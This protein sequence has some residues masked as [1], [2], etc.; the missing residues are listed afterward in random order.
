MMRAM[1]VLA[2]VACT[3]AEDEVPCVTVERA[4]FPHRVTA[5]GVLRA[6][7]ATSIVAP[8]YDLGSLTLT[9]LAADG[10]IIEKDGVIARFDRTRAE[11]NLRD[12]QIQVAI[13]EASVRMQRLDA[14]AVA[15]TREVA[16]MTA[17]RDATEARTV[18]AIDPLLYSRNQIIESSLDENLARARLAQAKRARATGGNISRANLELAILAHKRAVSS[19]EQAQRVLANVEVRAPH[20]GLFLVQRDER[21]DIP[22]LGS[23]VWQEQAL[24]ELPAI[25]HMEAQLFVLE[26]DG[27]G[28]AAGQPANIVVASHPEAVLHG[29]IA[30]IDT[31]AKPRDLRVPVQYIG[32]T[33]GLDR[34]DR[35]MMKPGQRVRGTLVLDREAVL[36]VPRQAVFDESGTAVVYRRDANGFTPIT[37]GLG[38]ATAGRI[39]IA[40][41]LAA[42]DV[43]A[44]RKPEG[45]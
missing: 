13:E 31:L 3:A 35:A 24:G 29:T 45:P 30:K 44:L 4:S 43:V 42:G 1:L 41:G 14:A 37:V 16:V 40:T 22:K 27:V 17:A 28:L 36:A 38:A 5:D 18:Q 7:E 19:V 23:R 21:G 12:A 15:G 25:E 33:V 32:V 20:T 9:Y 26:V 2:L 8:P 39:E 6:T 34:A 11:K 10:A